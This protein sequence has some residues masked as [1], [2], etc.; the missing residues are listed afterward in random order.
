MYIH[1]KFINNKKMIEYT[2]IYFTKRILTLFSL[3]HIYFTIYD[4]FEKLF[5]QNFFYFIIYLSF[6]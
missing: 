1:T 4:K 6:Q 2:K 3:N 5:I